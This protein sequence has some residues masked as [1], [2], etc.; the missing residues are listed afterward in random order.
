MLSISSKP[1]LALSLALALAA[2]PAPL[3]FAEDPLVAKINK[4]AEEEAAKAFSDEFK[5]KIQKEALEKFPDYNVGESITVPVK[6]GKSVLNRAGVLKSVS[7][8]YIVVS[9][10][11]SGDRKILKK[12]LPEEMITGVDGENYSYRSQYL[13]KNF[14]Q[15]RN[16]Y[17]KASRDRLFHENGFIYDAETGRW[18]PK[19]ASDAP[20]KKDEPPKA[21]KSD[22]E[23]QK[24]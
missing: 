11:D 14:Y 24:E 1:F 10:T 13:Q 7:K 6:F 5:A 12:E 16:L 19:Y 21:P 9:F 20:A 2:L 15:A 18:N 17:K 3:L 22:E 23:S 8:E 4:Q